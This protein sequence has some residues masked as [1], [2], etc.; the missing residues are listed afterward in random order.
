MSAKHLSP[1]ALNQRRMEAVR[2]RLDGL[3]V[4]ET[5]RRSGLSAPTISAA[6]KAFRQG[7]WS[8]VPVRPRGR[9]K[10]DAHRLG[11][12]ETRLLWQRL[13]GWPAN[14]K[15]GWT[16]RALSEAIN[17]DTGQ[18]VSPRALEHWLLAH[19]LKPRPLSLEPKTSRSREGRWLRQQVQPILNQVRALGGYNW[20][21]GVRAIG[22]TDD[23]HA[24]RYHLYVHGKRDVLYIRC[25]IQPPKASDYIALFERLS[26]QGPA[27]LVFH[28]AYFRASADIAD[29]LD[30]HSDFYLLDVPP[31]SNLA[32]ATEHD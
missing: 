2:L 19:H 30:R 18:K 9:Q 29:W 28:G 27:S 13:S 12:Q 16:S 23:S 31:D 8:A 4:A 15:P 7:G 17:E 22:S 10:G 6:W 25:F 14:G 26:G 32:A 3:T 11:E 21:G 5:A 24:R 20:L 1:E